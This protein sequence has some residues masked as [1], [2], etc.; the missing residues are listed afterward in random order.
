MFG[1]WVRHDYSTITRSQFPRKE[2]KIEKDDEERII[3]PILEEEKKQEQKINEPEP[4]SFFK[5]VS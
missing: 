1:V 5:L 2:T 3:K 4:V